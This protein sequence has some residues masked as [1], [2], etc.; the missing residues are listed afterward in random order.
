MADPTKVHEYLEGMNYPAE[1]QEIV[2]HAEEHGA[3][4][5]TRKFLHEIPDRKYEG[6]SDVSQELGNMNLPD[7]D[8]IPEI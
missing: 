7:V 4:D 2:D 8:D 5:E 3:D 6:P 1:K